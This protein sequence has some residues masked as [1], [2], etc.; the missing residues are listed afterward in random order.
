VFEKTRKEFNFTSKKIAFLTG[1]SG[2][3]IGDKKEY[4]E[5]ERVSLQRGNT[6]PNPA[7]LL[8]FTAEQ[9]AESGGYDAA[10]VYWSKFLVSIEKIVKRLKKKN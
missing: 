2:K 1:S 8:V 3:T 5:G 6:H 9:K 7:Q 10:I 4:F